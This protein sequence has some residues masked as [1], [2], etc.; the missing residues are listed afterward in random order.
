[1]N[2][3]RG[4]GLIEIMIALA[5][6]GIIVAW[7][8]PNYR[9]MVLKSHRKDMQGE[10]LELAAQQ[11]QTRTMTGNYAAQAATASENGRYSVVVTLPA[12]QGYLITATATG[13]QVNDTACGTLTVDSIGNRAPVSCWVK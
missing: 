1:M 5:V 2:K 12:A 10:M 13:D 9:S 4:F 6:V 8:L 7:A 3:A 11:E